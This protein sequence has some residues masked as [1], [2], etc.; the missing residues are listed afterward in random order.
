ME[1]YHLNINENKDYL[2]KPKRKMN[3][4]PSFYG[5]SD[6]LRGK[7]VKIAILDSGCPN[8]QDIANVS[9]S[10]DSNGEDSKAIDKIGHSTMVTGLIGADNK[11]TIKGLSP[12][13]EII[14]INLFN[15]NNVC[16]LNNILSGILMATVKDVNIILISLGSTINYP[17]L[18]DAIKKAYNSGIG[19]IAADK[20]GSTIYPASYP[21]VMNI[22]DN[23]KSQYKHIYTTHLGDKYV[24]G[25]GSSLKAALAA[26]VA[27]LFIED[28][29]I[30]KKKCKPNQIYN[31]LKKI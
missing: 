7:G 10:I 9:L 25:S 18:H 4:K 3:F 23:F 8:H 26:G 22:K 12:G 11:D 31:F 29:I 16:S 19:I 27:A 30:K 6:T 28:S 2:K 17:I 21:E 14:S 20:D 24:R 13:A 1:K 15:E 5:L